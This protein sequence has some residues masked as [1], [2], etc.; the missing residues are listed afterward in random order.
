MIQGNINKILT[1]LGVVSVATRKSNE[2][3]KKAEESLKENA[4]SKIDQKTSFEEYKKSIYKETE[5]E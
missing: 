2:M 4:Q 1:L 5:E 3:S